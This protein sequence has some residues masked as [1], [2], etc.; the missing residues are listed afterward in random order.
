MKMTG[1]MND[2]MMMQDGKMTDMEKMMDYDRDSSGDKTT[3]KMMDEKM[4]DEKMTMKETGPVTKSVSIPSGTSVPGCEDADKCF[5]P[6]KVSIN[7]GDTIS[8]TNDDTAVHTTTGGSISTGTTG[9]FD[10]GL[11]QS[12]V[13]YEY[14]FDS[15]GTDVP[16][17]MLTDFVTGPVSFIVIFS[18]IIFS[19]IIFSVVYHQMNLYHNPS[20]FPYLSFCHLALSKCHFAHHLSISLCFLHLHQPKPNNAYIHIVNVTKSW[21]LL[22]KPR[23]FGPLLLS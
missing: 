9:T 20:F 10:S 19:S 8:W 7:A 4:M 23:L 17:G 6:S 2:D 22:I 21:D 15:A 12:G 18:S 13:T 3:E 1:S 5:I 16:E 11:I 14:T